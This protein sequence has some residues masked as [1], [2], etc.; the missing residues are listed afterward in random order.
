MLRVSDRE[1]EIMVDLMPSAISA[2]IAAELR[3]LRAIADEARNAVTAGGS[4]YSILA[5]NDAL[6]TLRETGSDP[7]TA[8]TRAFAAAVDIVTGGGR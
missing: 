5:L 7:E 4:T 8:G 1:L 6:R 3:L 2:R